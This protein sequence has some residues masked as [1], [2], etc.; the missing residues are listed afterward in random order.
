M[1]GRSVNKVILLGRL[2]DDPDFRSVASGRSLCRLRIATNESYKDDSDNW[3]EKPSYHTVVLWGRTAEVAE[4]YLN[5]GKQV[6]IEGSLHTRSWEDRD[7][8]KRW[9]T[10]VKGRQMILLGSPGDR[11]PSSRDNGQEGL[12]GR[13]GRSRDR[14]ATPDRV[15]RDSDSRDGDQGGGRPR[16]TSSGQLERRPARASGYQEFDDR[17]RA[18]GHVGAPDTQEDRDRRPA[19]ADPGQQQSEN[20]A[21]EPSSQEYEDDL[22]F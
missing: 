10:E 13:S 20:H 11:Q 9:S 22:P 3:V 4:Q 6:Y 2:V 15:A 8:N 17:H 14:L 18:Q 1:A 7:G 19:H 21:T 5:K 16:Q 12:N